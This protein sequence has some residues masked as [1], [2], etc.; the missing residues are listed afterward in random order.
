MTDQR[1][2]VLYSQFSSTDCYNRIGRMIRWWHANLPK[3]ILRYAACLLLEDY[4]VR[5]E[6]DG[7]IGAVACFTGLPKVVG[8]L[9]QSTECFSMSATVYPLESGS[10]IEFIGGQVAY[11]RILDEITTIPHDNDMDR[12]PGRHLEMS[13]DELYAMVSDVVSKNIARVILTS[14]FSK[15]KYANITKWN[16]QRG[17]DDSVEIARIVSGM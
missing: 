4:Y 1:V 14:D 7:D 3:R 17:D 11:R 5:S 8:F 6:T 2:A 15:S 16:T 12:G 10:I 9:K 13:G